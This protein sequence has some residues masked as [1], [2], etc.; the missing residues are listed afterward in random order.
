MLLSVIGRG[1]VQ[2]AGRTV[3]PRAL[4]RHGLAASLLPST[5]I[6]IA[7][8]TGSTPTKQCGSVAI[9]PLTV[10]D[11]QT[12]QDGW[13]NAIMTISKV[14]LEGGDYVTVA[15]EAASELY[16]YGHMNVLFKPTK[17]AKVPFR[18][19]GESAMSYFVGGDAVENG[20]DEDAGFAINGGKG[21]A[22]VIFD[23]HQ[24]DLTGNV[25][26][27]MG[28]YYFTCATTGEVSRVE[29]TFGYKRCDDGKPRIFLHHSSLPYLP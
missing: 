29:Y 3:L 2:S 17:A 27:S 18:P 14:C 26:V 24:T 23:N 1:V 15:G 13:A 12:C 10:D 21:W 16:G 19:T 28:T 7:T 9:E 8:L 22:K 6:P 20:I 11:V 4:L 25:A 5:A